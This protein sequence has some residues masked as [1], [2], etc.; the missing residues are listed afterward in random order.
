MDTNNQSQSDWSDTFRRIAE[1]LQERGEGRGGSE[2]LN[3]L[4][5]AS[6]SNREF[7]A[8]YLLDSES[9]QEVLATDEM[10]ALS[11]G[12][13]APAAAKARPVIVRFLESPV[14]RVAASIAIVAALA[15]AWSSRAPIASL[16]DE[17][18]AVFA[19]RSGPIDGE[20]GSGA[21]SLVSGMISME[22]RNGVVM[23]V[24]SPADFEVVDA[25]RVRLSRGQVRA[26]APESGHGFV[27]ETPEVDIEDLGTEFGVYVD[28]DSGQSD[29]HVFDGQVDVKNHGEKSTLASLEIG[30]SARIVGGQVDKEALLTP[31]QFLTPADVSYSRWKQFRSEIS[32]DPDLV[33]YY[34]FDPQTKGDRALRDEAVNGASVDGRIEGAHWV[35]GRWPGKRALLFDQPGDHVAVEIPTPLPRFTFAAW[36]KVDRLDE[37]LTAIF[38]SIDWKE[39]SL[40]LQVSRVKRNFNPGVHPRVYNKKT[41]VNVP[42]G[43]WTMVVAVVDAEAMSARTWINGEFA[44][45]GILR[46][47]PA[48][49]PGLCLLGSFQQEPGGEHSR[50]FRGRMDEVILWKR[51]LSDAE[52]QQIYQNGRPSR[53]SRRDS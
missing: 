50:G 17:A 32:A 33:F 1:L 52:I 21:Y 3:A 53:A 2:E 48:I 36:V 34:G 5:R 29:V 49:D 41:D 8:Q 13:A 40:H 44:A 12:V 14:F 26:M 35:S 6:E 4:L 16:Q 18:N 30:D 19:D 47:V 20:F 10:A 31:G 46:E 39:G 15:Y 11:A 7:A 28:G 51:T 24:E 37:A 25:F 38:N 23:T 9:L 22:F 43:Q 45:D 42:L 27:I